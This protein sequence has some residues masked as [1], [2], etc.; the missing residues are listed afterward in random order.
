MSDTFDD[1]SQSMSAE[2]KRNLL[3]RIQASLN[4]GAKDTDS[5]VSKAD[6][7]DELRQRLTKEVAKLG[8]V[9][10][11]VV[12]VASFFSSRPDY[13]ILGERK[14]GSA[15][16]ALRDKVPDLVSFARQE[17]SAELG[18][19]I[20]DFYV[21]ANALK[22]LFD[23]LFQQKLT[24]E[25]GLVLLIR[26]EHP[27][28]IRSLDD[29]F[30]EREVADLYRQDP[31]RSALQSEL[32]Q[33]LERYLEGIP[34]LAFERAKERL[35]PLYYLRPLVMFPYG[36]LLELFGHNTD[37]GEAAKYPY[38]NGC[39]WRKAS[40][41]LERFYYGI[42]LCTKLDAKEGSLTQIWAAAAE[43]MTTEKAVWTVET[44][45]QRM[46]AL[47]RLA[48]DTARRVPWKEVL[49]WSFQDPYYGVKYVLPKFSVRE[50]Y[51]ATLAMSLREQ[52]DERVPE[53]RQ[54]LLGD[55]RAI[56]FQN[57][58]Y[59]PLEYYVPGVGSA[60]QK[61]RGF[62]YPETLGLLWGFLSHHFAKKIV[63]FHQ[64]LA[65]MVAPASKSSLQ[66]LS[67]IVEE[68]AALR[69]RIHQFDRTL[70]PDSDEGKDFQKLKYE[71]SS[72]ALGLKP[73]LQLIQN[74]DAQ[75]LEMLNRGLE[76]LQILQTQLAG[77]RDR[78]VPALKA[79]LKLPY[80]L[81]GQQET[82]ENG[83]ERLLVIVQ[84]TLFVLREAQSLE[85]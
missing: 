71:L 69:S 12:R 78:N 27:A 57:G 64:S 3:G 26:E 56:L 13:E 19:L 32:D 60:S 65:R 68:L 46:S 62:Q 36:F 22:P 48:Q 40:G 72:K 38:L 61:V 79:V 34:P 55:E 25:A 70:H 16:A 21:E 30:P 77:V 28:A 74:K 6:G 43:R 10:R 75:A 1:L 59:E 47:T 17:W 63:P 85:N 42:H 2:E 39:P 35:R 81:E 73:F 15:R 18:K 31:H 49:Q 29:L 83:L 51:H 82:I 24:L 54:K 67:N 7:P 8:F 20:F 84:K 41:L 58:S 76:G 33:R 45:T 53:L 44:I 4:L 80:L 11:L 14:L 50:F 9:D 5:I 52:L 23:H 66:G 37:K